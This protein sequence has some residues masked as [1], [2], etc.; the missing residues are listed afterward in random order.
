MKKLKNK[1]IVLLLFVSLSDAQSQVVKDSTS[2]SEFW[3]NYLMVNNYDLE[4]SKR[5]N[6]IEDLL[7]LADKK[8][9]YAINYFACLYLMS[10]R[11][12]KEKLEVGRRYAEIAIEYGSH[13][14][15]YCKAIDYYLLA[16]YDKY[17]LEL[18]NSIKLGSELAKVELGFFY[19]FDNSFYYGGKFKIDK[20]K[21]DS[22]FNE[23]ITIIKELA[24]NSSFDAMYILGR[25]YQEG[26][27]VKKDILE[28]YEWFSRCKNHPDFSESQFYDEIEDFINNY[29]ITVPQN[30]PKYPKSATCD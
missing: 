30:T 9:Y 8:N 29:T 16:A 19:L 7:E 22:R 20:S 27:Y 18:K 5:E 25:I 4:I 1:I 13:S 17:I 3:N 23:G 2:Y 26:Y 21:R 11:F 15:S 6:A 28:A 10:Y 12:D 14:A 24:T